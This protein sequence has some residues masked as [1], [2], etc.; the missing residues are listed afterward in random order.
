MG[1]LGRLGNWLIEFDG[2][3]KFYTKELLTGTDYT[4]SQKLSVVLKNPA[5]LFLFKLLPDLFTLAKVELTRKG[6]DTPIEK[7]PLL[8]KLAY[9]N[10]FQTQSQFLWDYMF[11]RLMGTANL[12]IDSKVLRDQNKFYFLDPSCMDWDTWFQENAKTIFIDDNLIEQMKA[13]K[14]VYRTTAQNYA[15]EYE[16]L[17]Q[18]FDISNGIKSWFRGPSNVDA[19]YKIISNSNH[20]IDS[21]NITSKLARK[22]MVVG[23]AA[24]E[25]PSQKMMDPKE[26]QSVE[27]QVLSNKNIHAFRSMLEVKNF[28]Q[29]ATV[30]ESLDKAFFN[31]GFLIGKVLNIPR[32]VIEL[33][34]SS[35]YENQEKA[36]AS[37]VGYNLEPAAQDLAT[38]LL[39]YF[40][41]HEQYDL[42]FKYDHLSFV[43]AFE[44]D[45]SITMNNLATAYM[46]LVSAGVRQDI[47]AEVVGLDA[48]QPPFNDPIK[49]LGGQVEESQNL[50]VV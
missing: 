43:Q 41:L 49:L 30:L 9:P 4:D 27:E 39:K 3:K 32:D 11:W 48:I 7:H 24:V 29:N 1:V 50:N 35:T 28:V 25:N 33:L 22:Y 47:A 26:Q 5:A 20:I 45:R 37:I 44:K 13:K 14:I 34:T 19:L 23:K 10:P 6:S 17:V 42:K 15:F 36:R 2:G 18:Y 40:D 46:K 8:D 38:G 16:K 12:Y 21:K 31:D